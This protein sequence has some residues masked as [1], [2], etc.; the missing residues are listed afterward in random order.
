M[1]PRSGSSLADEQ[2]DEGGLARAGR[3]DEKDELA[4]LDVEADL[5]QT[6]GARGIDLGYVFK[7]DHGLPATSVSWAS[8]E[9]SAG[10]RKSL[11]PL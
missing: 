6:D 11:P 5:L 10:L 8:S 1:R 9:Y 2:T 7:L 3:S 4:L